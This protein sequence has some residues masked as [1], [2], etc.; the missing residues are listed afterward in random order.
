MTIVRHDRPDMPGASIAGRQLATV[1][2]NFLVFAP[3]VLKAPARDRQTGLSR[4]TRSRSALPTPA[5]GRKPTSRPWPE[6]TLRHR[7]PVTACGN[8]MGAARQ[9]TGRFTL[10]PEKMSLPSGRCR[11][12]CTTSRDR[13]RDRGRQARRGML[14][15]IGSNQKKSLPFAVDRENAAKTSNAAGG[16]GRPSVK[17]ILAEVQRFKNST[18]HSAEPNEAAA[19]RSLPR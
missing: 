9:A 2:L 11:A 10:R 15:T 3:P 13:R 5:T 14:L 6:R 12:R 16:T 19:S 1:F 7:S 17:Q 8:A 18:P 4:Q